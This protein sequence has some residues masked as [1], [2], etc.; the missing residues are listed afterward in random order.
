M[1]LMSPVLD[2]AAPL[3]TSAPSSRPEPA[4]V[5]RS[6]RP[7]PAP[8]ASFRDELR[9]VEA[10]QRERA[11]A[12]TE[13]REGRAERADSGPAATPPAE[14]ECE[15]R[16]ET[17]SRESDTQP[18]DALMA[19]LLQA[20]SAVT[21]NAVDAPVAPASG[22]DAAQEEQGQAPSELLE[23]L[24]EIQTAQ[25]A[26]GS[27][28]GESTAIA[29]LLEKLNA[30]TSGNAQAALPGKVHQMLRELREHLSGI[31]WGRR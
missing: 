30:L 20:L 4:G 13:V 11:P 27:G 25:E 31:A 6:G 29:S 19:A 26:L 17:G 7:D 14:C 10:V 1:I 8:K 2:A 3:P 28:T 15:R 22:A 21:G 18:A 12:D 24:R 5:G 23:L 9:A 16:D